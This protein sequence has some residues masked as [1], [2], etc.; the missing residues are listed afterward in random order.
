MIRVVLADDHGIVRQGVRYLLEE[1]PDILVVGD[2]E[3]GAA[4][5][6]F[7]Q[8]MRPEVLVADLMMPGLPGLDLIARVRQ[9]APYTQVVVL[10]MH[11]NVAH[12]AES[13]RNG[14]IGYVVKQA[15]IRDL[16][17]AVR[18]A[19]AGRRHLS[20]R[21]DPAAVTNYL[22]QS[23]AVQIDPLDTLSPR[24]RQVLELVAQGHT[25]AEIAE[26]LAVGRRTVETHRA[27]M[28]S[29]LGLESQA[30]V[31]RF[32]LRRGL[33]SIEAQPIFATEL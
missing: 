3:D 32:A 28:M 21:I 25:N 8:R 31:I 12:V 14:A 10:S 1:Q 18:A 22:R 5:M 20:P 2:F 11:V 15:D 27:H 7:V 17:A 19:A 6:D 29:K 23:R 13:L 9:V 24:E 16:V 4:A 26:R 33:L 30:D